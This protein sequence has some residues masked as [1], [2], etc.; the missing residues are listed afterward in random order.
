MGQHYLLH[1]WEKAGACEL[2]LV[3]QYHIQQGARTL[4]YECRH[5]DWC[6]CLI[7]APLFQG[8]GAGL[9]IQFLL[10]ANLSPLLWQYKESTDPL[11]AEEVIAI[12]ISYGGNATFPA[13]GPTWM[14]LGRG[15]VALGSVL[16]IGRFSP[17]WMQ[18]PCLSPAG[19]MAACKSPVFPPLY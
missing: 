6:A 17:R 9:K 19:E 15:Q 4:I 11:L 12:A 16:L 2:I 10:W 14:P 18:E 7:F 8:T 1:M 5:Q 13:L 3:S